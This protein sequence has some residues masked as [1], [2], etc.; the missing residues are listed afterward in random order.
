MNR[1][2]PLL[3]TLVPLGFLLG[4]TQSA[5]AAP[6]AK[7]PP[8]TLWPPVSLSPERP[9]SLID[10]ASRG[11]IP[12]V[13][14]LLAQGQSVDARD[15][16]GNTPLMAALNNGVKPMSQTPH[17]GLSDT[18]YVGMVRFLLAHGAN[19]NARNH[20]G[21]T[22][23][24]VNLCNGHADVVPL[25]IARGAEVNTSNGV[26]DTP[27]M[28]AIARLPLILLLLKHGASP[29]ALNTK[30]YTAL[31]LAAEQADPAVVRL[32]LVHGARDNG[33]AATDAA[34]V[35]RTD[36]VQVLLQNVKNKA[37]RRRRATLALHTAVN[38]GNAEATKPVIKYLVEHEADLEVKGNWGWT[39]FMAAVYDGQLDMVDYFLDHGANINATDDQGHT[40]LWRAREWLIGPPKSTYS[41]H[42]KG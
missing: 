34:F 30:G 27:L 29:N 25:L 28:Y 42:E 31:R 19:V 26:G 33:S 37:E 6:P 40:A 35:G 14:S 32:L 38:Q 11:D 36:I 20:V 8:P 2:V 1:V 17:W 5:P 12:A 13:R 18:A 3:L 9:P 24:M 15:D 10:A 22:P 21:M 41:E 7:V 4:L 39:P 16:D 23:L